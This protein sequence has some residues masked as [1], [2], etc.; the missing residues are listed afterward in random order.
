LS[1]YAGLAVIGLAIFSGIDA[2]D[3]TLL[4]VHMV[5]HI[6]LL[7]V[8]PP[9][10]V[11]GAPIR[12][13][14]ASVPQRS[15]RRLARVLHSRAVR[16]LTMPA[17]GLAIY[18]AVLLGTH[19]TGLYELALRDETVHECEHVAYVI[20]GLLFFAPIIAADPLPQRPGAVGRLVLF[21]LA[22]LAMV[23]PG[24]WLTF[25]HAVRYPFYIAPA[26]V[27][28]DSVLA[29]QQLAG[30][31]MIVGGGLTMLALKLALFLRDVLAEE[32]RQQRREAYFSAAP[33]S[34]TPAIALEAIA[35][36]TLPGARS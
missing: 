14:F 4:S 32:R 21:T 8:A 18:A 28:H 26:R 20:A 2:Y 17:V 9:L 33:V 36:E 13:A 7:D 3:D 22:M 10:L 16:A 29:D 23:V 34:P 19:F 12:L 35:A 5:Q 30:M 6:L 31:I 27:L 11:L 15:R 1:F 24:A 25:T